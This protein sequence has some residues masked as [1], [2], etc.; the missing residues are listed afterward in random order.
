MHIESSLEEGTYVF[1]LAELHD[2]Y[3]NRFKKLLVDLSTN[4]TRLKEELTDYFKE[5]RIQQQSD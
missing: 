3:E 2:R 4:R 1:K 5:H